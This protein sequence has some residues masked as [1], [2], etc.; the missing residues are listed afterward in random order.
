MVLS[1]S[2]VKEV[3]G[4][5]P[6]STAVAPVN[7]VPVMVTEVPPPVDPPGGATPVTVGAGVT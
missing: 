5:T 7:P 1:E 4:A 2:I 3:A 6:K